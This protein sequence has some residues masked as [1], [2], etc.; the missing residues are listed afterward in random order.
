MEEIET[1]AS[2]KEVYL[3]Y[4]NDNTFYCVLTD[5]SLVKQLIKDLDKESRRHG[6]YYKYKKFILDHNPLNEMI[7]ATRKQN[8]EQQNEKEKREREFEEYQ[9]ELAELNKKYN[10]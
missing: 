4:R 5:K 6:I 7:E 9:K 2:N 1:V 3:V 10:K 8:I